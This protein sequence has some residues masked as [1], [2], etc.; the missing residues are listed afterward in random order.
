MSVE[1]IKK[2]IEDLK[3][4]KFYI[5]MND[6]MSRDEYDKIREI[7][8]RVRELEEELKKLEVD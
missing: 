3:E 5:E 8:S 7:N 2:E 1:E 6:H 4:I